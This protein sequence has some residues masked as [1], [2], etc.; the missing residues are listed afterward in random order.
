[1]SKLEPPQSLVLAY[2]QAQQNIPQ[3]H[4]ILGNLQISRIDLGGDPDPYALIGMSGFPIYRRSSSAILIT[5]FSL[6]KTYEAYTH[7]MTTY[8]TGEE[9][10][11]FAGNNDEQG[12]VRCRMFQ[13]EM[14]RRD[15]FACLSDQ[16]P[17]TISVSR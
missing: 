14:F 10:R 6:K 16:R 5:K 2:R 3:R 15:V 12:P 7:Y 13:G 17:A 1:M 11:R 4:S 9:L 8:Q